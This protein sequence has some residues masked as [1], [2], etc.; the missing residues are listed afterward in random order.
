MVGGTGVRLT[1]TEEASIKK[2]IPREYAKKLEAARTSQTMKGERRIVSILFCDVKGS[3]SMAEQLD[4]EEWAEIM[5]Q[6][7]EYL[8]SPIYAYEGTLARLMGDSVLAFFGAPIGHENDARRAILAGLKIVNDIQPFKNKINQEYNLEFNVRVGINTGLV[9]VGGVGSDL[10]MEYT[11]LGDAINIASRLEQTALPGTVQVGEDTYKQAAGFFEFESLEGIDIRGKLEPVRAYRVLRVLDQPA[12]GRGAHTVDVPMVGRSSELN[13]LQN[14]IESV[15]KEGGQIVCLIGEAG[16]GKSRLLKEARTAWEVTLPPGKPFGKI[17]TRWNQASSLSYESSR[18]YGLIQ[19]LIR[20]YIGFSA[21][22]S[23]EQIREKLHDTFTM[24]GVDV[25]QER[26]DLFELMLGVKD[27]EEMQELSGESLKRRMYSEV[28]NTLELLAQ[29]GPVVI[30]A[31][32]LH[33]TDP[34]SAELFVHLFQLI[35]RLPILFICS[36]RPHHTSQAWMVKQA[37][38]INYAHRYT[39]INLL[40]LSKSESNQMIESYLSGVDLPPDTHAMIL[41]KSDGNPFFMEEVIRGLIDE[42]VIVQDSE[43][44][45]WLVSSSVEDISI[46]ENLIALLTAR[47]DR[48]GED[49][50]YVLQIAS[51]IG[52]SFYHEV[53]A[54]INDVSDDL[55][56]VLVTLQRMGLILEV[57]QEPEPE[58]MFRQA[59]TQETAYNT[60]LLK[61]RRDYH[62]RVGEAILKLYPNR[63]EEFSS[64]L[65]HH[66]Y[67]AQDPRALGYFKMDGDAAFWIYANPEAINYYSKAIEVAKWKAEPDLKEIADLYL[68]RGRAYE[69]ESQF[70][71]ALENYKELEKL[72]FH[73]EDKRNHLQALVAQAQIYSVPSSEFSIEFGKP[74]IDKAEKIAEEL[75]DRE[76]LVKIYRLKMNLYRFSESREKLQEVGEKTIALARELNMEEQLAFSLN[77]ASHAYNMNGQ[78]ERAR[79]IALEAAELWQKLNNLPML[80]DSLAG[81]AA[82]YVYTG[83]FD[84]AYTYSDKAFEISQ[85][86]NNVWGQSYSRYAIG[87]VDLERGHISLSIDHLQ[88]AIRDAQQSQFRAGEL[89]ALIFLSVVYAEVGAYQ[90]AVQVVEQVDEMP[91]DYLPMVRAS[92]LGGS[93]LAN[94]RAGHFQNA[95]KIISRIT[96]GGEEAHF[97]AKHYFVLGQCY[98]FLAKCDYETVLKIADEYLSLLKETGV[99]FLISE[100]LMIM[101]IA[102]LK[103]GLVL[104]AKA[105]FEEGLQYA[106]RLGSRKAFWQ[107]KYYLGVCYLEQGEDT[108]ADPCFQQAKEHVQYI[109]EHIQDAEIKEKFLLKTEV[110]DLYQMKERIGYKGGF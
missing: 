1:K 41:R 63:I 92:F 80:A 78:V 89:L 68:Y 37:A 7:F 45:D 82:T 49:A 96:S 13:I 54:L 71:N 100:L 44:G 81:L 47:I 90:M 18:P 19:R 67:Q 62:R 95:E 59:L 65:G 55:D 77:D 88:Q 48:L 75:N 57:A 109:L 98:L 105:K 31:D 40:P 33:W 10:F 93:L 84:Q 87:L 9:V 53:L 60:I 34:A 85:S 101:G 73:F 35:D 72:A 5:N 46:P 30:A 27:Q 36:F 14:V 58:Y 20:N 25:N 91:L 76:T 52:R 102:Y 24:I 3:T 43:N 28:L 97:I 11:A 51:V 4:P 21:N 17:S 23:S 86:I 32:D 16:I 29:E 6:A 110:Q 38:E 69:L 50:K 107:I 2:F 61:H 106:E 64:L 74:A 94:A 79:E 26:L 108:K 12:D 8:I 56:S 70:Q 103:Q 22:D 42:K 83:E 15:E 104:E 39:Q 99:I 66:F